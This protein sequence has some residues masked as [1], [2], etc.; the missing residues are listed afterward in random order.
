MSWLLSIAL[1]VT[2]T[3]LLPS[4]GAFFYKKPTHPKCSVHQQVKFHDET[5]H[6]RE[7]EVVAE[8]MVV[9]VYHLKTVYETTVVPLTSYVFHTVTAQALQVQVFS[10]HPVIYQVFLSPCPC[11][12]YMFNVYLNLLLYL[13]LNTSKCLVFLTLLLGICNVFN[14]ISLYLP[15]F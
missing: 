7:I 9:P 1:L 4:T 11:K 12:Y 3:A 2:A 8:Q 13:L 6:A 10:P 15:C 5:V 14:I